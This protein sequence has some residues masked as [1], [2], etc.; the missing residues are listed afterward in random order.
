M[1]TGRGGWISLVIPWDFCLAQKVIDLNL[2]QFL[3][4]FFMCKFIFCKVRCRDGRID[5]FKLRWVLQVPEN[6]FN[7]IFILRENK[8]MQLMNIWRFEGF[9][10]QIAIYWT[11]L[12]VMYWIIIRGSRNFQFLRKFGRIHQ[13]RA[14]FREDA[15][16]NFSEVSHLTKIFNSNWDF[17]RHKMNHEKP[18]M[19]RFSWLKSKI[20]QARCLWFIAVFQKLSKTNSNA[21]FPIKTGCHTQESPT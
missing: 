6:E 10:L 2:I 8:N 18:L 3:L 4:H 16:F 20:N 21:Q 13:L 11:S 1:K 14:Q 17:K 15:S 9:R 19:K 5:H 7:S 12:K